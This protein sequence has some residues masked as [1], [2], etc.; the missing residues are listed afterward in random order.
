MTP[1]RWQQIK[2]VCDRALE[3]DPAERAEVLARCCA[4]DDEMRREVEALLAQATASDG[5]LDAPPWKPMWSPGLVDDAVRAAGDRWMPER[6]GRYRIVRQVGSGGM[7]VVYEAEQDMPRRVVALKVVNPGLANAELLRRFEFESQ[8]LARLQHVGIAQIYEAGVADAGFGPQP[9]FAME[10]IHGVPLDAFATTSGLG[11]RERMELVAKVCEAVEHAHQRGIIHRDLK[12]ANIL[13]DQSGPP[14]ILDFGIARAIDGDAQLSRRTDVGQLIGTLAYMSPEQV[15]ADPSELDTRTDVYSL[16]VILYELLSGGLPYP[17]SNRVH[18]AVQTIRDEEPARLSTVNRA[19]RGDVETIVGKALEKD[20]A[21][22]YASAAALAEDIRRCL[23]DQPI[24]ARPA[25]A[26][27]QLSKFARRHKSVVAA[28][29]V[30]FVALVAG[31]AVSAREAALARRAE[32]TAEAV[33]KFLQ[34]DLLA[35]ASATTQAAPNRKPDP[36]LK[37]RTALD[38]AAM[39]VGGRFPGQPEVEAAVRYTI[40]STYIELGLYPEGRS[41]LAQALKLQRSALG[42]RDPKTLLTLARLGQT[43]FLQGKYAE[44]E[45]MLNEAIDGQRRVLGPDHPETLSTVGQMANV[46]YWQAKYEQSAALLKENLEGRRRVFGADSREVMK[47]TNGLASA[48]RQMGKLADSETLFRQVV[49]A[50]RRD[51]G[52]DH[53]ETLGALN[54]QAL[55]LQEMGK[56]AE[57]QALDTEVVETRRRVLGPEHP[58]TLAAMVNLGNV[59]ADQGKRS[60][61]KPLYEKALEAQR[62]VLGPEHLMTLRS[63]N[64]LAIIYNEEGDF[65]HAQELFGEAYETER[66]TLGAEHSDTLISMA[67]LASA[68]GWQEQYAMSESLFSQALET[69]RK[70]FGPDNQLTLAIH[71]NFAYT[72]QREGKYAAAES[73]IAGILERRRRVLGAEHFDTMDSTADLALAYV[74]QR[75]FTLAEPLAR[76]ALEWQKV[77]KVQPEEWPR[78]RAETLLGAS[79]AGQ[80]KFADAEPLLLSGYRGMSERKT[81]MGPQ[82]WYHRDRARVWLVDLY[83]AWGKPDKAAEWR[84]ASGR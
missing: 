50:D 2:A 24:A 6:I 53:P 10:F 27:Y 28:I 11:F 36:D 70:V 31:V 1:E 4:A 45:T 40:G 48:Y 52:S 77:Q 19:Y 84:R 67:N 81:E 55:T 63:I 79:L 34:D 49:A 78:Y 38:R 73:A 62:R 32:R 12:P 57:A 37:V 33:T 22:R 30:I 68:Y 20:K 65:H 64:N 26:S 82:N 25:S 58:D 75:K 14:K 56:Y 60:E 39:H 46:Y 83:Q 23:S 51:L 80:N 69:A 54:N 8:V 5:G 71:A 76:A 42:T 44:A 61:A 35:K 17:V 7:G 29:A 15:L 21:R 43:I 66:R 47:A 74:S 59:V 72:L 13:V 18:E 9:Y 16:G 41:Q 3:S